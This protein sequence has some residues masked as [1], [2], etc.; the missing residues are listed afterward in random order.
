MDDLALPSPAR[1]APVDVLVLGSGVAGLS[2]AVHAA[3]LGMS[4]A[5]LTKAELASSATQYAQGG[6]AA[7]L[8]RDDVDSPELHATD[9]LTAGADLCDV[10]AVNVLVNE[11]PD[12]VR[13]L[14]V[15]NKGYM[16]PEEP[17][18]VERRQKTRDKFKA[19][20]EA[21]ELVNLEPNDL[22]MDVARVV[23]DDDSEA[24]EEA[25]PASVGPETDEE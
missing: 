14:I 3:R 25:E 19:L 22:V 1:G 12:C 18:D 10:D 21:G 24:G 17:E 7:A 5:V 6:V 11:G 13:E 16:P 9:T 8:A 4:V 20:L 15:P 23:P 2:V